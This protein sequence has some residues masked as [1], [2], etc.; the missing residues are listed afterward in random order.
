[1]HNIVNLIQPKQYNP[2]V[3]GVV[4]SMRAVNC[5]TRTISYGRKM[6]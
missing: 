6:D 1:M 5:L 2:M 4:T 3:R